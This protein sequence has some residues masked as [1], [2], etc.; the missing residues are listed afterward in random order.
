M[1]YL[2]H[3]SMASISSRSKKKSLTLQDSLG[4]SIYIFGGKN[5]KDL[6]SNKLYRLKVK[7]TGELTCE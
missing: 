2:S 1:P 6:T 7:E 3:H 5:E 4:D